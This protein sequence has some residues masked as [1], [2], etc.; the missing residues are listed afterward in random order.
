M[1]QA[2]HIS[3]YSTDSVESL[4]LLS[5]D[6]WCDYSTGRFVAIVAIVQSLLL[7][8]HAG[9]RVSICSLKGGENWWASV[10]GRAKK[11]GGKTQRRNSFHELQPSKRWSGISCIQRTLIT[12]SKEL[13]G[14][15]SLLLSSCDIYYGKALRLAELP[16]GSFS[17][18]ILLGICA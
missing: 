17:Y 6:A 16:R 3:P 7:Y 15:I 4:Q 18:F 10:R 5:C 2:N 8:F 11:N 13:T 12:T 1:K 14:D 9:R